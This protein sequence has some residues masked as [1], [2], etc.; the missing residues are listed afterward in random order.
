MRF[1]E[2]N[3]NRPKSW[4]T[5]T[6]LDCEYSSLSRR[7]LAR[8]VRQNVSHLSKAHSGMRPTNTLGVTDGAPIMP[9]D[10][11]GL[12]RCWSEAQPHHHR[13]WRSAPCHRFCD[14]QYPTNKRGGGRTR[15]SGRH[16][17][18]IWIGYNV[19][20]SKLLFAGGLFLG[21]AGDSLRVPLPELTAMH[22]EFE[23]GGGR[24][25]RTHG[26]NKHT[27][28]KKNMFQ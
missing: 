9:W 28:Y 12:G 5:H 2:S 25:L 15:S 17:T 7:I 19:F 13:V 11:K 23:A 24:S 27:P 22:G 14:V 21:T 20:R 10:G 1:R 8:R 6:S 18:N 4:L 16:Y 3:A 26:M